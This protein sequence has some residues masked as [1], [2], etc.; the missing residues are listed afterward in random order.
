MY[1]RA[2]SKFLIYIWVSFN[3]SMIRII[4]VVK[5]YN[6]EKNR[7]VMYTGG[8]YTSVAVEWRLFDG[9]FMGWPT[10]ERYPLYSWDGIH[11]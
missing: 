4:I 6:Q 3:I 10:P 8:A 1:L 2:L 11:Q 7:K 9:L 5:D